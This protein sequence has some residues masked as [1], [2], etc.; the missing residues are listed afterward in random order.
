LRGAIV[1]GDVDA[2]ARSIASDGVVCGEDVE[3][4][5]LV[6]RRLRSKAGTLHAQLFD[7]AE[8]RKLLERWGE[9]G[10]AALSFR[11]FFTR[12]KQVVV[13]VSWAARSSGRRG[14]VTWGTPA[15]DPASWPIV[16]FVIDGDGVVSFR[17]FGTCAL[18]E[19]KRAGAAEPPRPR[20]RSQGL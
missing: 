3:D 6:H 20:P 11:E 4:R 1:G 8:Y 12:A 14:W 2:V 7:T 16:Q 9:D 19:M 15:G 17:A 10:S 5:E 13:D 18:R